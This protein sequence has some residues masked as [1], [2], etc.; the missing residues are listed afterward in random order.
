MQK[1]RTIAEPL[2]D[3]LS[4][5]LDIISGSGKYRFF[6]KG[7]TTYPTADENNKKIHNGCLELEAMGLIHRLIDDPDHVLWTP[8]GEACDD[9]TV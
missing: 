6:G 3:Q 2:N 4:E 8:G 1:P 5:L 9:A 7:M